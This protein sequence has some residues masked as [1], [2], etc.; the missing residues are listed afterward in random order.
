[1]SDSR[2]VTSAGGARAPVAA[3]PSYSTASF[4]RLQ[5]FHPISLLVL[6]ASFAITS[7]VVDPNLKTVS[8]GHLT[9][10]NPNDLWI[11]GYWAVLFILQVGTALSIAIAATEHTR[12]SNGS[13]DEGVD[14][15]PE[16]G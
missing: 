14:E 10:F 16:S 12:V 6:V 1:M 13:A 7:F 4:G 3:T 2:S 5:I 15:I 11:M 9:Y 8:K